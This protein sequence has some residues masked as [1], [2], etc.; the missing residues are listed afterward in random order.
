DD[1]TF[2]RP[3]RCSSH[4]DDRGEV[5]RRTANHFYSM[6]H[7]QQPRAPAMSEKL[8]TR[9]RWSAPRR[10]SRAPCWPSSASVKHSLLSITSSESGRRLGR[11]H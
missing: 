5:N 2:A 7:R 4:L 1:Q 9:R 11:P 3:R 8:S 6:I 10:R